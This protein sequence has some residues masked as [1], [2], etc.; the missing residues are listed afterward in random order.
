MLVWW[1]FGAPGLPSARPWQ[2]DETAALID[3]GCLPWRAE[4]ALAAASAAWRRPVLRTRERV[5]LVAIRSAAAEAHPLA[6]E[7]APL[8]EPFPALRPR[9]EALS[10]EEKARLARIMRD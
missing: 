4:D 1:G 2:Q 6:H 8:L 3:A 10:V 7:F 5:L 9:A